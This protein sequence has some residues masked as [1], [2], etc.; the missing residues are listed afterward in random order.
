MQYTVI[1]SFIRDDG[2]EVKQYKFDDAPIPRRKDTVN[3]EDTHYGKVTD[4]QHRY[5]KGKLEIYV[6]V[7][8]GY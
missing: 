1:F 7:Q 2:S 4:V 3:M 8:V 6:L 5:A